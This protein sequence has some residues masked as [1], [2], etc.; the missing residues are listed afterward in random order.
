MTEIEAVIWDMGGILYRT[1]FE[2]F[3]DVELQLGLHRESLPRGPFAPG[4]DAEYAKISTGEL[5]ERRTSP[6]TWRSAEALGAPPDLLDRIDWS[7]RL[8]PRVMEAID[9]IGRALRPGDPDRTTRVAGSVTAGGITWPH[10]DKFASVIDVKTLGIRKPHPD[11]YLASARD[12]GLPPEACLFVD[13]MQLNVDG[14]AAVGMEGFFFD[15]TDVAGSLRPAVRT[16]WHHHIMSPV[17]AM[18]LDLD[19]TL[20]DVESHVDYCAALAELTASFPSAVLG[21]TPETTGWGT[22]TKAVIARLVGLAGA[23]DYPAAAELVAGHELAG[24]PDSRPMPGLVDFMASIA[25]RP[26]AIVTLLGPAAT[27]LVLELHDIR[28]ETVVAREPELRPKPFPDQLEEGLR[29]L[30]ASAGLATMVGDSATDL[31]AA[32]A[33]GV[34]F[35]AVTNGRETH[36]FGDAPMVI[37]LAE[38]GLRL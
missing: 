7:K 32:Q 3:D 11:T 31:Q 29:R 5:T 20:V 22:C 36:E 12:L 26:T 6:V 10:R 8:R 16:A 14:A 25:D 37:G 33:A 24:A 1:P 23:A 35:I 27:E 30:G 21:D 18:L 2:A 34:A 15:H 28:V 17:R 9:R 13:D 19:R 4:G 38:A